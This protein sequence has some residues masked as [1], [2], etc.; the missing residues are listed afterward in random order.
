MFIVAHRLSTTRNV[1]RIYLLE[2]GVIA[3]H[4]S[5]DELMAAKGKYHQLF[6]RQ[7]DTAEPAVV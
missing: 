2:D 4:G 7:F 3:E 6:M 1:D 5:Y